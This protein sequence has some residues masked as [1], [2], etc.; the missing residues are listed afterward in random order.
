MNGDDDPDGQAKQAQELIVVID[1]DYAMRLSCEQILCKSGFRVETYEDGARGLQAIARLRPSLVVVDLKMPGIS[2]MEVIARVHEIDPCMVAIVITGYAT[3]GTAVEAMKAGAYDFLPKPFKPEELRLIVRRGLERRC[4]LLRARRAEMERELLKRRFVTFVSHELKTPL[5]AVHQYI[6]VLS[7]L[8]DSE[9]AGIDRAEWLQRCLRRTEEMQEL[10]DD[11]LTLARMDSENLSHRRIAIDLDEM[12]PGVLKSY[13]DLA[14][15]RGVSLSAQLTA[16]GCHVKGDPNCMTVLL[17]NLIVN[18][19]KYNKP[20]GEVIVATEVRDG[21][22]TISVMDTGIG[23][24]EEYRER[25][26][27]EF[28]RIKDTACEKV[29]GTGLGLPICKRIVSEM[30]GRIEVE[31]QIDVGSTFHVRLPAHEGKGRQGGTEGEDK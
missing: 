16:N 13:E 20:H 29:T 14:E 28:F 18:A 21:E 22:V 31:S 17:D 30:G 9:T 26:F 5:A 11:W 8:G 4:L 7:Q 23:I 3:I 10:I 15:S 19:I 1:D 2:G 6:D 25:L 27:D 24:P 12:I